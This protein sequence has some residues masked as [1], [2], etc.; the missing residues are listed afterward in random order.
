MKNSRLNQ[1]ELLVDE[2]L[3]S[4]ANGYIGIRGNFEEGYDEGYNTIR[5][6]Y[7]NGFYETIDVEYGESAY[8]FPKTAQKI[9]NIIDAQGLKI[10]IDGDAFNLFEGK[11]ITCD[12]ELKIYEGYA[13]RRVRWQSPKGHEFV[14]EIK[15]MTSFTQLELM[16]IEYKI[17]SIN[18]DGNV[19]VE[20]IVEGDVY[21]YSDENDPRVASGHAKLLN[22]L[23]TTVKDNTISMSAK[24]KRSNLTMSVSV[25]HNQAMSL[26]VQGTRVIAR[27][28]IPIN[29]GE[30]VTI[31]KYSVYTDSIRHNSP[32]EKGKELLKLVK[33]QGAEYWFN[34]QKAYLD[35]FWRYAKV[36][37]EG[38]KEVEEALNYSVYQL[39]ASAG[40][41]PHSN[42]CAKGLSGEGYEGHYF[43]DTEIYMIPFFILT[44]PKIAKNLLR[45]RYETLEYSRERARMMG[46]KTGAKIPWRTISGS[47]CSAFFPA[48]SAQYHINADVAYSIIQ[49]YLYTDDLEYIKDYGF[50]VMMETARIWIDIGNFSEDGHFY[51]NAVTGPDEYTAI[52]NNNYYTNVMA[53]YHL[54]WVLRFSE[55]LDKEAHDGYKKLKDILHISEKELSIMA[56]ASRQMYLPYSE[57]LGINLQDD[58]LLKRAEWDF[59]NTPKENYPLLLHYHPLTIY[60]HKVLKQADTVLA[61]L[62]LDN[63]S[64]AVIR[65][66][67][68]YYERL[69]THD[70]S[71][72]S[73]VYSMVASR[74]NEPEKAYKYF[75]KTI[76]LD[77]DNL[78]NNTK[79][80]L[81]IANA[82]GAYMT[83]VYGF[84]GLRI[85]EA[86]IYLKPTKPKQWSSIT[87]RL[88]YKGGLVMIT[89][90][91]K[92]VIKTEKAITL[93][94]D[95]E[96]YYIE[97]SLEV[98][99]HGKH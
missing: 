20:S 10:W 63:E 32:L 12:R 49:Y 29:Q 98:V 47:E 31:T 91:E 21:N 8:G 67:Y 22:I 53:K 93:F 27:R 34:N 37:V 44:N 54:V 85:K 83:M 50:E 61:H 65:R 77:L 62:L 6:T 11:V 4:T 28:E 7:I 5:G 26:E 84:A 24:T 73:C 38:D 41:E 17:T 18:F 48:G 97:N 56:Q 39:L 57:A 88:N 90:G 46:H 64:D 81:H 89:I 40:K 30:T 36:A 33:E 79:D 58:G 43:W 59:A 75:M 95:D 87:F 72:S 23:T 9:L 55:I 80:G 15:R 2:T 52:V 92:L 69:T 60:R 42:I 86:G 76:R 35:E 94:V 70:S 74:I 99:Y 45:F 25:T 14:I 13:V 68:N 1:K 82:G 16:L 78:H 71:L 3:L 66:S 96:A 19:K 51:I